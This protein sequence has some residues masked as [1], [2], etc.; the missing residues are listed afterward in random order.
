MANLQHPMDLT[1]ASADGEEKTLTEW[2]GGN[3]ALL[4]DFWVAG[5]NPLHT[6]YARAQGKGGDAAFSRRCRRGYEH[7]C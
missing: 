7:R 3:Q 2:L 5:A 4:I 6:A 1:I